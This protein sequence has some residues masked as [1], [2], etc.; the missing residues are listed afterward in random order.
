[1]S[2]PSAG[3]LFSI[4]K[5]VSGATKHFGFLPPH[6]R[7][8]NDDEE[9]H[10]FGNVYDAIYR[11]GGFRNQRVQDALATALDDGDLEIVSSPCTLVY[12][13]VDLATYRLGIKSAAPI[14][15]EPNWAADDYSSVSAE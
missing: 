3:C 8:L 11:G 7:T 10:V 6:G 14:A 13:E 9:L 1:M 15:T 12:D 5:N 2:A 4:V